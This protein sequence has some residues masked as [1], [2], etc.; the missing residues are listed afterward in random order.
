MRIAKQ[1]GITFL[2]LSVMEADK[3]FESEGK[4]LGLDI[5]TEWLRFTGGGAMNEALLSG[6]LDIASGG[7]GPLLI[8]WDKTRKNMKVKGIA[9]LNAIPI[10]LNTTNPNIK[11]LRDFKD[12]DRIAVPAVKISAQAI[13]LQMA[14]AQEFGEANYA[15]LNPLTISMSHPDAE[16]A[17][18]SG[19]LGLTAHF[20]NA[21]YVYQ[22]LA[23]KRVRTILR[24]ND[25]MGGRHT[26]NAVWTS[27]PFSEKNPRVM[28]AFLGAL[29]QSIKMI[30][31]YPQKAAQLW[32]SQEKST[33]SEEEAVKI[34]TD[35]DYEW[36]MT[37][38]KVM[39]FASFM[40]KAGMLKNEPLEWRDVFFD[41]IRLLKGN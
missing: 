22:E 25:V 41:D 17:L 10:F 31:F 9:A 35:N 27:T 30:H 39:A 4:K 5:D 26:L 14:A 38:K 40:H 37:P 36:T 28:L 11:S 7:V 3:L 29:E 34:I 13:I 23:D 18:L 12:D 2:P 21:P 19:K 1:Y 33:L 6:N 32:L 24:S 8:I 15:K 16:I 20:A